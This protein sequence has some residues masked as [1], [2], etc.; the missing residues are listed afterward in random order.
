MARYV[1]TGGTGF[2]G[3]ALADAV[4]ARGDEVITA[5]RGRH[6]G[7]SA[8]EWVE[9]D[10]KDRSTIANIVET[11]PDGIYHLAWSTTPGTAESDATSDIHTN[12]AGTVALFEEVSERL[13]VP[14]LFLSSGGTVYGV[15]DGLPIPE[16]HPRNPIS[17]Y[18]MTKAA[19]ER[20]ALH[21][22]QRRGLDVRIARLSNPF[23]STQSTAKQQGAASIFTRKIITGE[24]III[25]GDGSVVRDYIHVEDAAAALVSVMACT[26]ASP[27]DDLCFNVGSGKG[28]SLNDLIAVVA[29]LANSAANVIHE[30][31]RAF[32]IPANVLDISR[33]RDRLGWQPRH[34]IE[35]A[36]A[37]MVATLQ[38]NKLDQL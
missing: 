28:V 25:W 11:K 5:T 31:Q 6:L 29:K 33:I 34:S 8:A 4:R 21:F 7:A 17:I 2:V 1:I 23:G 36:L 9:Y 38:P 22:R 13:Q 3:Q 37:K 12:L 24:P 19:A 35:Q 14:L 15:A 27:Y 18:G 16:D 30:E 10:L 32:D 20:Y 26:G